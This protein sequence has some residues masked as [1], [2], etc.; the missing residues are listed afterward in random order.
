MTDTHD[1]KV[2]SVCKIEKLHT[3]F[4]K[5]KQLKSG[6]KSACIVCSKK[7]QSITHS[8]YNEKRNLQSKLWRQNNKEKTKQYKKENYERISAISKIHRE[9]N[10]EKRREQNKLHK[11]RKRK[12]NVMYSVMHSIQTRIGQAFKI[13]KFNK[14]SSTK[15]ILGCD[16]DF[17][18][19]HIE[20]QFCI[21]M[22]WEN[23]SEWHIDHIIP[24]S[25]AKTIDDVVR[26]NHFT[27]LRPLWK[28]ENQIKYNKM[29]NLI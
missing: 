14:T 5:C 2:C 24:L 16:V 4:Y 15:E 29:E 10:K 25:S 13:K 1:T 20:K 8:K 26:L 18:K 28:M 17:F 6:L 3:D 21:G 7:Q 27:N 22:N 23:R 19:S 11:Q 12:S 9:K